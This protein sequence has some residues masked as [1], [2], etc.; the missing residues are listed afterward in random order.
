MCKVA[1][2]RIRLKR[3]TNVLKIYNVT[4]P[5]G[6]KLDSIFLKVHVPFPTQSESRGETGD[7][8]MTLS[9]VT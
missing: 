5:S 6:P 4:T 3:K 2:K 8:Q 7:A 1:A 9:D